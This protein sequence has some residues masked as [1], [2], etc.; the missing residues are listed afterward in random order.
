M[1]NPTIPTI[2][3]A[4]GSELHIR[5]KREW[6]ADTIGLSATDSHGQHAIVRLTVDEARELIAGLTAAVG[7]PDGGN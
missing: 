2:I 3:T 1:T 4:D 7:A 6:L 5:S